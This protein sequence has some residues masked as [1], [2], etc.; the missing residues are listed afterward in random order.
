MIV[1]DTQVLVY[2]SMRITNAEIAEAVRGADREWA[3]PRLWRSEFRNAVAG[4]IRG[5]M[6]TSESAKQAFDAAQGLV[7]GREMEVDSGAVFDLVSSTR[8]TA[9]DLEFVVLAQALKA[10]LVTFDKEVLAA[11]PAVA[12]R[13]T[14]FVSSRTPEPPSA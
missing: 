12:M 13:P 10:P 1:V 14:E 7:E 8:I 6:A 3:A 2:A 9:Y 5:G 11:F 4:L